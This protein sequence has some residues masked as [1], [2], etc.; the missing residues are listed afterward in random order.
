MSSEIVVFYL[1]FWW[2]IQVFY[3]VTYLDQEDCS[4]KNKVRRIVW[5]RTGDFLSALVDCEL[6]MESHI[7]F[8]ISIPI[9]IQYQDWRLL[10]LGY[11]AAG[12]NNIIKRIIN[13]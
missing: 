2:F 11:S 4:I 12:L 10:L 7:G 3:K 5:K 9:A 8:L 1:L 13:E 6:C